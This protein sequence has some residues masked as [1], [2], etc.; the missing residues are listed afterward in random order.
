MPD[1]DAKAVEQPLLGIDFVFEMGMKKIEE[2]LKEIEALDVKLGILFGFLG[3]VLVALIAVIFTVERATIESSLSWAVQLLLL[4]GIVLT[5]LALV[6]TFLAFR[7]RQYFGTPRFSD[8]VGWLYE[9][10]AR[11]KFVF[12]DTLLEA[13]TRNSQRLDDKQVYTNRAIW[14]VFLGFLSFLFGIIVY[15]IKL[16]LGG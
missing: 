4:L 1:T 7:I 3:T 2:Q 14:R 8:M 9:D 12:V 16:L 13:V 5:G 10:A 15:S 11:T 6:N